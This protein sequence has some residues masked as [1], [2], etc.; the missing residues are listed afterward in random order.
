MRERRYYQANA[1]SVLLIH[2]HVCIIRNDV[3]SGWRSRCTTVSAIAGRLESIAELMCVI[4]MRV[5]VFSAIGALVTIRRFR[6][7]CSSR[8][9][10]L[11]VLVFVVKLTYI[12][13]A[14]V[15]SFAI[16]AE[17]KGTRNLK[18]ITDNINIGKI[19]R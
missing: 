16:V 8:I 5:I 7:P 11:T 14:R 3:P 4:L 1:M 10:Y 13:R 19:V 12:M 9:R 15:K 18:K 6:F 2:S 17:L